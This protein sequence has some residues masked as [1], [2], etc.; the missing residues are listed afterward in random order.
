M[1]EGLQV[2]LVLLA[3]GLGITLWPRRHD[4]YI[5]NKWANDDRQGCGCFVALIGLLILF[6][7]IVA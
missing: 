7:S 1:N 3:V 2:A 4:N 5:I 6:W